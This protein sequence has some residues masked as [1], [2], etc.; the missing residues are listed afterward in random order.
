VK[1]AKMPLDAPDAAS[2]LDMGV[3]FV[4]KTLVVLLEPA[5][6]S[7][8]GEPGGETFTTA[9]ARPDGEP[10][11]HQPKPETIE[12]EPVD[13]YAPPAGESMDAMH[14]RLL[15]EKSRDPGPESL[16]GGDHEAS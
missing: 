9:G 11:D 16:Q 4:R 10:V 15:Q 3:D 14:R 6:D 8:A 12:A 2:R 5:P 1:F 13:P 7:S